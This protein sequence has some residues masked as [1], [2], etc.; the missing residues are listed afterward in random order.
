MPAHHH[1][2]GGP[3]SALSGTIGWDVQAAQ[4][5][6]NPRISIVGG[7]ANLMA[8]AGGSTTCAFRGDGGA[9]VPAELN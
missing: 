6:T 2:P 1:G 9:A 3:Q 5:N 4:H 7:M 8:P